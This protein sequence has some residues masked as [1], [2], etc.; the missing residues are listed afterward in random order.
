MSLAFQT[1]KDLKNS[2]YVLAAGI[3]V[4]AMGLYCNQKVKVSNLRWSC[5]L[6][7]K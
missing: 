6:T 2:D 7:L 4:R 5:G 3:K 1:F